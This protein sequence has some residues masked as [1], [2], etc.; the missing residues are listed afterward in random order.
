MADSYS[1]KAI[2]SAQDSGFSSTLK[3]CMGMAD[4]FGS[5]LGSFN[6]GIF[7]GAGQAAFNAVKNG[8]SGLIGEIDSGTAPLV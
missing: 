6:F 3:S 1:V 4:T 8:V 5:K 7:S 2:L